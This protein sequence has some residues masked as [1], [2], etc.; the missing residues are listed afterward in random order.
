MRLELIRQKP[1]D[2]KSLVYTDFTIPAKHLTKV[3][4]ALS[5]TIVS[6]EMSD[7]KYLSAD[8]CIYHGFYA[9]HKLSFS[10]TA[11]LYWQGRKD[12]NLRMTGSK[13]VA[14]TTWL[15]PLANTQ[16]SVVT[17]C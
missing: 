7:N 1:R 5:Y 15:L 12:L 10:E 17:I 14:V 4:T 16:K 8:T 6:V 11:G 2:F 9:A 3:K 13:P